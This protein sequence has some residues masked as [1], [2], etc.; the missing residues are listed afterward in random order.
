MR[1]AMSNSAVCAVVNSRWPAVASFQARSHHVPGVGDLNGLLYLA[2]DPVDREEG[3]QLRSRCGDLLADDGHA[4]LDL[5][6]A[7]CGPVACGL[8]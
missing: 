1:W 5:G 6:D 8:G 4:S 7:H 3:E 2:G